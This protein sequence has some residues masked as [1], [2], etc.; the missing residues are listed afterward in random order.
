MLDR[1]VL[2]IQPE[3]EQKE[4]VRSFSSYRETPNLIVLGD[5]GAGKTSLFRQSAATTDGHF[6]SV[7]T[8]LNTPAQALP[9]DAPLWIDALD[10][11]RSGRGDKGTIDRLIDKLHIVR[12]P[13]VRLSCRVADWL[14]NS[15]LKALASYFDRHGGAPAVIQLQ[16]LNLE[17][18]RH[19]LQAHG[20]AEPDRFLDEAQRR[21]LE[22]MLSNPQTLLMLH[23]AVQ[24]QAWPSTRQA[25]F[26][27]AT[28]MLLREHNDEHSERGGA[29][30]AHTSDVLNNAAGALCALRLLSDCAG[31]CLKPDGT[32]DM[33]GWREIPL[34]DPT[35]IQ[36]VLGRRIFVAAGVAHGV[37]YLHRTV[38]EYLGA[39]WLAGKIAAGL[40]LC[41][42]QALLGVDGQ[43]ASSLR[44]L[45]AWLAVRSP[46]SAA[47]LIDA[48]PMGIVMY[49]DA[50]K[51]APS[52]KRR[53]LIA[54]GR[55]AERD[56]W[57]YRGVYATHGV[58]ALSDPDMTDTFRDLLR[59]AD[60][61]LALRNLV[62]DALA[63]GAPQPALLE[64]IHAILIDP[65]Q[66]FVLRDGCLDAL[67]A[68]EDAGREAVL[69]AYAV[70][71]EDEKGLRLRNVALRKLYGRGLG[72]EDVIAHVRTTLELS[73]DGHISAIYALEDGIP[74]TDAPVMLDGVAK[75]LRIPEEVRED[76]QAL[77]DVAAFY[78]YMLVKALRL[79]PLP[80]KRRLYGWLRALQRMSMN[81]N[82]S[83]Y[84]ESAVEYQPEIANTVISAWIENF[85]GSEEVIDEWFIYS[86]FYSRIIN[87]EDIYSCFNAA[88]L[89]EDK[90]KACFLY[91]HLLRVCLWE[92]HRFHDRFWGLHAYADAD[93]ALVAVRNEMCTCLVDDARVRW[94]E[95]RIERE[96]KWRLEV[97]EAMRSF[98]K[99]I[100]GVLSG[101]NLE[102]MG[103]I[104]RIYFSKFSFCDKGKTPRQRIIDYFGEQRAEIALMGL[105]ALIEQRRAPTV[106]EII[107]L[108]SEGKFCP[109][110]YAVLA[111]LDQSKEIEAEAHKLSDEYFSSALSIALLHPVHRKVDNAL[112]LWD[113]HWVKSAI[114]LR[115]DLVL[116]TY[117]AI[118]EFQL[119]LG[120]SHP[121]GLYAM[122]NSVFRGQ[123]RGAIIESLL[124]RFPS[125]HADTL[126][127]LLKLAGDDGVWPRLS[128][129]IAAGVAA[130]DGEW[131]VDLQRKDTHR[132]WLGFGFL[133]EPALY[134]PHIEAMDSDN[135]QAMTWILSDIGSL[136]R[137]QYDEFS[138]FSVDQL[139]FVAAFIAEKNPFASR[140]D[141]TTVGRHQ[142][143]NASDIVAN[144]LATL[145]ASTDDA[146][147]QALRRLSTNPA[148]E[149]YAPQVRHL[150]AQQHV[151]RVDAAHAL[152]DW[153][154]AI[155]VL[156][157]RAPASA[158]DLHA[159]VRH[160]VEAV[161][162]QIAHDNTDVY[163]RFWNEDRH[164]R[165]QSAKPENS[166]R[167][168]LIDLLRPRLQPLGLRAEPEG[169]TAHDKRADIVVYA[170]GLK[171]VIELKRDYHDDVWTAAETQLDRLYARDPEASGY[172]IY[173]VF[174]YGDRHRNAEL[175]KIPKAPDAAPSPSTATEMRQ[176]LEAMLP[177]NLRPKIVII[178]LDV[179]GEI[180]D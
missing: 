127:V 155:D 40:P 62:V 133:R 144:A 143:W 4:R 12:P 118:L 177:E 46:G 126:R 102:W 73:V 72:A 77:H 107:S 153:R 168:V 35:A 178:V 135:A 149:S 95:K 134:R 176:R 97:A 103:H 36:A 64:D 85:D 106:F 28:R 11:T 61:P 56:P 26:E 54:L 18:Q 171:C 59:A 66:P 20:R 146:A 164:G 15:D 96:E 174:W 90:R 93:V 113:H 100:E 27:K 124:L 150:L 58:G 163:K 83:G 10:E 80:E 49:A 179:S 156:E 160:H 84:L 108:R 141:G 2:Q 60:T 123:E 111:G 151:R 140:P 29:A 63:M 157:N 139:E 21:G 50:S 23:V 129:T 121:A 68:M 78:E 161:C 119:A 109:W 9:S 13:A 166:A 112:V 6:L 79:N 89:A 22:T 55:T 138:N 173:G 81:E 44:G 24:D 120:D 169:Q 25:L 43:S 94:S 180:E 128:R 76:S 92:P 88:L 45:H 175:K 136:D 17:E 101:N 137:R 69:S 3:P 75:D 125:M 34:A 114:Q 87:S 130:I 32:D 158:Q 99:N 105:N 71:G 41:R 165:A 67:L 152:S 53:L 52:D 48:D 16:P 172:G 47:V 5:P 167:D 148:L 38:A 8:F 51:L 86:S 154:S 82:L 19:V 170:T 7:R 57:F 1:Q 14:G 132:F 131:D 98:D 74:D 33:P 115:K 122:N 145:S 110:W 117:S 37:D 70:L 39:G 31:F 147:H 162:Q 104:G 159:L 91:R 65:K 30:D 142:P 42:V 116:R